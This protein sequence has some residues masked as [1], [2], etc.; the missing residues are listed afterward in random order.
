[1][2][3]IINIKVGGSHLSKDSKNAGVRGEGNVTRLRITFDNGWDGYA[4]T[5]TFF[6]ARGNNPVKRLLTIDTIED[7]VKDERTYIISIPQEPLAIAGEIAFV[8]DGFYGEFVK[9]G[10]GEYEIAYTDRNKRQRSLEDKLIVKDSP[11]TD[12]AK[13]P[14]DPTPTEPEQWQQQIDSL[15]GDIKNA[16]I[17]MNSAKSSEEE[18][19]K[20]E[21]IAFE[22]ASQAKESA[23]KAEK[24][25]GKTSYI[26]LNGN[27]FA[28]DSDTEAFYDT[29]IKAQAGSTVYVGDNPPEDAEVWVD[30]DEKGGTYNPFIGENGNWYTFNPETQTFT[31]SGVKAKGDKGEQ[32]IQGIQGEAGKDGYTPKKGTDYWTPTDIAEIKGY[33]DEAI[34]GGVW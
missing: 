25:V 7:I 13:E 23:D 28:W 5:V 15:K 31:D 30:P 6:D 26:G 18:A 14:T 21:L 19:K 8:I 32:G 16:V 27:W 34:L 9:N 24:A 12:S 20:S 17:A 4:K 33:V 2:D 3:R 1:M 10:D 11:D 29:M 22:S